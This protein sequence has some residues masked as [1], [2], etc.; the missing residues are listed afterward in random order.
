MQQHMTAPAAHGSAHCITDVSK[1]DESGACH[2]VA[3]SRSATKAKIRGVGL[4]VALC[5][6]LVL[7]PSISLWTGNPMP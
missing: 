2:N 1:R 4:V 7:Q 3:T 5:S 6:T